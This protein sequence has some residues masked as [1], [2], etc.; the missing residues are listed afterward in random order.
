MRL[1]WAF[2]QVSVGR[3]TNLTREES[4]VTW[5]AIP[6]PVQLYPIGT[7]LEVRL[8][9]AGETDARWRHLCNG[10]ASE[11]GI[12]VNA[13]GNEGFTV[14]LVLLP[15]DS[16]PESMKDV[17]WQVADLLPKV[18]EARRKELD[19]LQYGADVVAV[20]QWC[21]DYDLWRQGRKAR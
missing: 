10:L 2:A 1:T 6:D 12:P 16:S 8:P 18:D 9:V 11:A 5:L 7:A 13:R 15:A 21:A 4:C 3:D 17:L 19:R 14:L 20:R